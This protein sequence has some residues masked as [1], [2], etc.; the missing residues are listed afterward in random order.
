[1]NKDTN[2]TNN[3]KFGEFYCHGVRP[4]DGYVPNI[5]KV[6]KEL[7][8]LRDIV[9]KPIRINSGYRTKEFNNSLKDSSKNSMHLSGKA[10]D[11][12]ISNM[13]IPRLLFYVGRYTNF[14]GIGI[15]KSFIHV[16]TR[17]VPA[18]WFY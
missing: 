3:F 15:S 17:E 1:M 11:I 13:S 7:Q 8:L 6:A 14:N 5:I 12:S 10:C 16:D 18:I 2:I 4:P 9:K